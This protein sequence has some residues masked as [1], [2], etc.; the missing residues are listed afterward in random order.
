[1]QRWDLSGPWTLWLHHFMIW[2][3][4][5]TGKS[6]F[7][8]LLALLERHRI[9]QRTT[10]LQWWAKN[11]FG[12]KILN[13]QVWLQRVLSDATKSL[14][15]VTIMSWVSNYDV[16]VDGVTLL[17]SSCKK[18]LEDMLVVVRHSLERRRNESSSSTSS[19]G[20]S[21]PPLESSTPVR[22]RERTQSIDDDMRYEMEKE[23][24]LNFL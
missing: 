1:M 10:S 4:K 3:S 21:I 12:I 14:R 15:S 20:S 8:S 7:W 6:E 22:V 13:F 16:K 11:V 23:I 18:Y 9:F 24:L 5:G 17:D 2:T 19:V